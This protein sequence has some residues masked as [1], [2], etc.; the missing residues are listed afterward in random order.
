[1]IRLVYWPS[2]RQVI[3]VVFFFFSF[4]LFS[5]NSRNDEATPNGNVE[6]IMN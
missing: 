3:V 4:F 1:M 5:R 6:T 2:Q